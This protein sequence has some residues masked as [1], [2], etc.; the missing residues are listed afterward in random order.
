MNI[1]FQA[2]EFS[3]FLMSHILSNFKLNELMEMITLKYCV[4]STIN[5]FFHNCVK[6]EIQYR[7]Q[8]DVNLTDVLPLLNQEYVVLS[9][10]YLLQILLNDKYENYD[11]DVFCH[12]FYFESVKI[13]LLSKGYNLSPVVP[14]NS[15]YTE[16]TFGVY[17]FTKIDKPKI[18]V[19]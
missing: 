5:H 11:L 6:N 7:L 1:I 17:D 3:S 2:S 19:N 8:R 10:S 4:K 15:F 9:G 16:S 14:D 12:L 18:Q 13:K